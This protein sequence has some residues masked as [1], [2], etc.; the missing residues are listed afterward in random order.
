MRERLEAH[1]FAAGGR[2][3]CHTGTE[4]VTRV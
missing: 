2:P 3:A 4:G 1:E